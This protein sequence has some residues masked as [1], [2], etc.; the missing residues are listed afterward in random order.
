MEI[1]MQGINVFLLY[2]WAL[3]FVQTLELLLCQIKPRSRVT[4]E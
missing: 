3:N 1:Y 2:T 4:G